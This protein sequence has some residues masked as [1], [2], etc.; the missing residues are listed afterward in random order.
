MTMSAQTSMLHIRVE[1]IIKAQAA[2]ALEAMSLTV[3][4]AVCACSCAG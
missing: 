3:S 1:D 2:Q 4:D